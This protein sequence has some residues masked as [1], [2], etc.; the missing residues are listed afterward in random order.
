MKFAYLEEFGE[1]KAPSPPSLPPSP[2]VEPKLEFETVYTKLGGLTSVNSI[3]V[4]NSGVYV[5]V[6]KGLNPIIVSKDYGKT[7]KGYGK[8]FNLNNEAYDVIWNGTNFLVGGKGINIFSSTDGMSWTPTKTNLKTI[9]SIAC[10]NTTCFAIGT[11]NSDV[12]TGFIESINN[13]KTWNTSK[14]I[15]ITTLLTKT[16]ACSSNENVCIAGGFGMYY[17]NKQKS[18]NGTWTYVR[19]SFKYLSPCNSIA[20]G[21][22]IFVAVGKSMFSNKTIFQSSEAKAGI[23]TWRPA[24]YTEG[25]NDVNITEFSECKTVVWSVKDKCFIVFG[26]LVSTSKGGCGNLGWTYSSDGINWAKPTEIPF[27]QPPNNI[28]WN[29][30]NK[31]WLVTNNVSTPQSPPSPPASNYSCKIFEGKFHCE[32]VPTGKFTSK[33]DCESQCPPKGPSPGP[34]PSPSPG[35]KSNIALIIILIVSSVIALIVIIFL[36]YKYKFL[37]F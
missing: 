18:S 4:N 20:Y 21:N 17:Y 29:N 14:S 30:K 13:G 11:P 9:N 15:N 10:N 34:G 27:K 22:G 6:G 28:I 12:S 25:G 37:K 5:A 7:W 8:N 19:N 24:K 31:N 16:L 23:N 3:A 33:S 1:N 35:P 26:T 32:S 2:P 36:M